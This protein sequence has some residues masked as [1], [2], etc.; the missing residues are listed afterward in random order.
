[1]GVPLVAGVRARYVDLTWSAPLSPNGILTS[2]KVFANS[3]L[4]VQVN[5]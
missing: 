3:E 1:M 4:K 5:G 2:Y